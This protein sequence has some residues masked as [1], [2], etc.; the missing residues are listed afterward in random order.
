MSILD[1]V[2]EYCLMSFLSEQKYN[3]NYKKTNIKLVIL[4]TNK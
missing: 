3:F 4:I 1:Y 2:F